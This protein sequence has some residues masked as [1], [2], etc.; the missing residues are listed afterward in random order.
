SQKYSS[1]GGR[2]EVVSSLGAGQDLSWSGRGGHGCA[3]KLYGCPE[4][5]LT[6]PY[7][8]MFQKLL[9]IREA[10]SWRIEELGDALKCHHHLE[11]F[12]SAILPSQEAVTVLGMIGCDGNGKL[13]AKSVVLVGDREHSGGAQIPLDLSELQEYS[14]F[15]G[16]VVA[17][18]GTNSTGKRLVV[19][20]FY[21]GVPLPF[22]IPTETES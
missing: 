6:K 5:Q 1:R 13:N 22:H 21:E 12:T 19:S 14:L 11:N 15:P 10:L 16:Q 18:E 2:G 7:K 20:K 9:D 8:F 17:L 3:P 4:E